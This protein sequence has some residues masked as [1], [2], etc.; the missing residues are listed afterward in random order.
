M[1][2]YRRVDEYEENMMMEKLRQD[3]LRICNILKFYSV[4]FFF[5]FFGRG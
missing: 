2:V 5:F 3:F 1:R 4:F